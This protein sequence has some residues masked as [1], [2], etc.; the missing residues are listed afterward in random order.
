MYILPAQRNGSEIF[1]TI[2]SMHLTQAGIVSKRLNE[3]SHKQRRANV[4]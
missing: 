3:G 2:A 4:R 1:A